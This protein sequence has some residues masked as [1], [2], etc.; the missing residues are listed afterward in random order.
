M[1]CFTFLSELYFMRRVALWSYNIYY[2]WVFYRFFAFKSILKNFVFNFQLFDSY[3]LVHFLYIYVFKR[4]GMMIF[5][6]QIHPLILR[7]IGKSTGTEWLLMII[8]IA[9]KYP[10]FS[11]INQ[12]WW[13]LKLSSL[14]PV[15]LVGQGYL[16]LRHSWWQ[17][18]FHRLNSYH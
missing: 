6:R 11:I 3:V 16:L 8:V 7:R 13:S 15:D 2:L 4:I 12:L 10:W 5:L 17:Q 14:S 18:G 1:F 9:L